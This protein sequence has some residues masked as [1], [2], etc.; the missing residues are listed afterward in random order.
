MKPIIVGVMSLALAVPAFCN[1][2]KDSYPIPCTEL[3][4]AV[5]DTLKSSNYGLIASDESAMTA[6]YTVGNSLRQR[7]NSVTLVAQ[8]NNCQ[9]QVNSAYRGLAHDDAGDFKT[10]VE[11]FLSKRK[12]GTTTSAT[13]QSQPNAAA[14]KA[15]TPA[16]SDTAKGSVNVSSNPTGGNLTVDGVLMGNTP[17]ALQLAPGKHTLTVKMSGYKD[18]SR[19]I[20]VVAGSD[21]QLFV[22][23]EKCGNGHQLLLCLSPSFCYY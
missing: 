2:Q 8:G 1:T 5:K 14:P 12:A 6:S 3:W 20:T 9:M 4:P 17:A 11:Q 18:W 22:N 16:T 21:V 7:T 13:T 15:D 23:L 10:R 19:E